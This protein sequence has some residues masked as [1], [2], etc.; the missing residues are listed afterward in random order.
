MVNSEPNE[1]F[2]VRRNRCLNNKLFLSKG[3]VTNEAIGET[4]KPVH[5]GLVCHV[6]ELKLDTMGN[7]KPL[8][9]SN[10]EAW[11]LPGM[12]SVL[13]NKWIN[14]ICPLE[15]LTWWQSGIWLGGK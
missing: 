5:G 3:E 7:Q 15:R 9:V 6:W 1:V 14:E 4:K 8:K 11:S 10:I 12:E 13:I 2:S